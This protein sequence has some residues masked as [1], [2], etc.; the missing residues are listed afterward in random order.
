MG[1]A[2]VKK[3]STSAQGG[4]G[5]GEIKEKSPE[6]PA[7]SSLRRLACD[8]C[9]DREVRCDEARSHMQQVRQ[10]RKHLPLLEPFEAGVHQDGLVALSDDIEQPTE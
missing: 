4:T 8:A 1:G 2:G 5:G 7:N 6:A 9:R 10:G 3:P